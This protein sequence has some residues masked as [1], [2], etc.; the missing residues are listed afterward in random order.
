[1]R[2]LTP[3]AYLGLALALLVA[4]LVLQNTEVVEVRFLFWTLS[5]S[6]ALLLPLVFIAGLLAGWALHRPRQQAR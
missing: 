1:M 6:R 3:K 5:M 4:V 2:P